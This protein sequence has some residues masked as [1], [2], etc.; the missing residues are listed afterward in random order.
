[1]LKTSETFPLADSGKTCNFIDSDVPLVISGNEQ[2]SGLLLHPLNGIHKMGR[3]F[4]IFLKRP[5][6]KSS[7][8]QIEMPGDD[9]VIPA[10]FQPC[11]PIPRIVFSA[12]QT[13]LTGQ[14]RS[15]SPENGLY[16]RKT[17]KGEKPK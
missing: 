12:L 7:F 3:A 14:G 10:F 6:I 1:M 15:F 17:T 2:Q 13:I 9:E 5:T 4:H 16:G 8:F 11:R